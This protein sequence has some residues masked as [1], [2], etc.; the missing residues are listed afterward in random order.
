[1]SE[2]VFKM[3]NEKENLFWG[4]M[5]FVFFY[6]DVKCVIFEFFLDR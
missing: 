3:M 1:M 2:E 4:F 5:F 6:V